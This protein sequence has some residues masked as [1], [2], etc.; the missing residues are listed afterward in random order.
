MPE[1][2]RREA[3]CIITHDR[4]K[5]RPISEVRT[6]QCVHCGGHI[7]GDQLLCAGFCANCNGFHCGDSCEV[8]V[9]AEQ[10]YENMESGRP[11]DY[12]PSKP[13]APTR[14]DIGGFWPI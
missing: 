1:R 10:M 5:D 3:G 6:I 2:L 11:W 9:P 14:F 13:S 8:C 4:E 12:K 7:W